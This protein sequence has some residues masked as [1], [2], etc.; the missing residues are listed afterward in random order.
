VL[1]RGAANGFETEEDTRPGITAA[2][3]CCRNGPGCRFYPDRCT[4][5]HARQGYE[6]FWEARDAAMA[7]LR[8]AG[9]GLTC[10]GYKARARGWATT[11]DCLIAPTCCC[12]TTVLG[13]RA[14]PA[15]PPHQRAVH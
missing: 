14:A 13:S 9:G 15:A 11:V 7:R 2:T 10:D 6:I 8:A 12:A 4:F 1:Q 5:S 3:R